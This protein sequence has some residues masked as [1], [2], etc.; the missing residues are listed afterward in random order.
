[1][2]F[3]KKGAHKKINNLEVTVANHKVNNGS[4]EVELEVIK[5][6]DRGNAVLKFFGPNSKK[7]QTLLVS[8]SRNHDFIF[9]KII[10]EEVIKPLIDRFISGEG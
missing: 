1:L 10:S 5:D 9:V 4:L 8:K 6:N 7:V 3:F 2:I